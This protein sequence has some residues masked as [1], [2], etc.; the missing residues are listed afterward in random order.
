MTAKKTYKNNGRVPLSTQVKTELEHYF[1]TL[2]GHKPAN[3]YNMVISE[4][5]A[6]LLSAVMDYTGGNQTRA[7][8]ILGINR[9]TLRKK[10]GIHGLE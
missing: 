10:L 4:V 5:E 9:T 3:L 8:E 1:E 2:N 7:A 6:P